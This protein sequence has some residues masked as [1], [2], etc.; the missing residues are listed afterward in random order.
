MTAYPTSTGAL[1]GQG[2]YWRNVR[3]EWVLVAEMPIEYRWHCARMLMRG[4]RRYAFAVE[5]EELR[6][7]TRWGAPDDDFGLSTVAFPEPWMRATALYQAL[8]HDFPT[9]ERGLAKLAERAGHHSSCPMRL[10]RRLRPEGATC[11]CTSK[12]D[13]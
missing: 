9:G 6:L 4:A 3:K 5:L 1:L 11:V 10:R 12:A 7:I 8:T 13:R 2:T